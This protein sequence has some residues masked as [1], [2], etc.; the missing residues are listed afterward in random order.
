VSL[1]AKKF[2]PSSSCTAS[3]SMI[4]TPRTSLKVPVLVAIGC[5]A[6]MHLITDT[7]VTIRCAADPSH[8]HLLAR[9]PGI[10]RII[11][12][13]GGEP[14]LEHLAQKLPSLYG[15]AASFFITAMFRDRPSL[16]LPRAGPPGHPSV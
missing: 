14:I 3:V 16:V 10:P 11:A 4:C 1:E 15:V 5:N 12:D 6:P 9:E 8:D 13:L 2:A 7:T